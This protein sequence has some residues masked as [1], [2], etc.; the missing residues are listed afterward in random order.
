MRTVVTGVFAAMV[1]AASPLAADARAGADAQRL[2]PAAKPAPGPSLATF[3]AGCFWCAE[4]AFEGLP[5]VLSVVSGYAGGAESDPTYEQVSSGRT[6][7]LEVVQVAFDPRRITYAE[8]L[9]I[10]WHNIDPT[11][12][13]GQFCDRGRQYRSA[14]FTHGPEQMRLAEASK[15][16]LE[17]GPRRFKGRIVTTIAPAG[18]FWPAEEYHQD[19]YRKDPRRYHG[20]RTGCG[21][22]RR[23][24][25]LWGKPGR[26]GHAP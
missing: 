22:D 15:R 20:Y 26:Q 25:E 24:T 17:T 21:R 10:F 2:E 18:T 9:E 13:D 5:G 1:L 6:G 7:H 4:T 19:F 11:Q 12:A 8:L 23:L 3:A 16:K 14:I